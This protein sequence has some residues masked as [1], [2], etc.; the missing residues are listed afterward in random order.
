MIDYIKFALPADKYSE[1]FLENEKYEFISSVKRNTGEEL[2]YFIGKYKTFKLEVNSHCVTISGSIHKFYNE[3]TGQGSQNFD[4]FSYEKLKE[5]ISI[6][7]SELNIDLKDS[8]VQNLEFGV[9][10]KIDRCPTNF[11]KENLILMKYKEPKIED[12]NYKGHFR[13]F[14]FSQYYMKVYNKGAQYEIGED[15]LRLEIKTRKSEIFNDYIVAVIDLLEKSNL[16][17]LKAL[18]MK[19]VKELLICDTIAPEA[20]VDSIDLNKLNHYWNPKYW[21]KL[22]EENRRKAN[23]SIKDFRLLMQKYDYE[24]LHHGIIRAVSNKFD[25]LLGYQE[26]Q[27]SDVV[28]DTNV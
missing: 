7:Q 17:K 8:R 14:E 18:L 2:G 19:R 21:I 13:E 10:I 20:V 16:L 6:I 28:F 5:T 4:D 12:F 3:I 15:I 11:L 22:K 1:Q 25:D 24:S 27:T 26:L 23:R 9:N